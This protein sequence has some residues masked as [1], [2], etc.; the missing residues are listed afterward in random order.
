MDIKIGPYHSERIIIGLFA[1]QVPLTVRNFV[2]LCSGANQEGLSYKNS[3]FHRIVKDFMAQ[4]GDIT[5]RDGTGGK[6]IYGYSFA[7]ENF[8]LKHSKPY[9]L[10]MANSGKDT[11]NS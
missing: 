4:A 7:D 10:S 2:E 6:S 9:L 5:N 1:N 11:N 8:K 3:I